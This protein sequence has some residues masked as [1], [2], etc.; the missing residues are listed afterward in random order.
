VNETIFYIAQLVA[1]KRKGELSREEELRLQ[2]LLEQHPHLLQTFREL[3]GQLLHDALHQLAQVDTKNAQHSITTRL[4]GAQRKGKVIST[5]W[6]RY[7]AA[8]VITIGIGSYVYFIS[9][10]EEPAVTQSKQIPAQTDVAPGGNKA[11]LTL[12]DG[13]KI[14]LDSLANGQIAT[15][16]NATITK[17]GD[18]I[19]YASQ[20][21]PDDAPTLYNTMTTPRGGQYQLTLPDGTKVWLNAESSIT[22]PTVFNGTERK[23]SITGEAYFEVTHDKHKPFRV[24][25]MRT[26]Y[27]PMQIEVLGTKFNINAYNEEPVTNTTLI[28]G[29]VRI[30]LHASRRTNNVL[31]LKPG[32]QGQLIDQKLVLAKDPDAEQAIAWKNG[33]F[34]FN[35]TTVDAA[36]RQISRWYD[37]TIQYEGKMPA[38]KF[39]GEIG[40]NLNL[41]Q[42]LKILDGVVVKLKLEGRILHVSTL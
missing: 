24:Q 5:G 42:L 8:I 21:S 25:C 37:V 29:S 11:T 27:P 41:S 9:Q 15:Q 16:A 19:S 30:T 23:V 22:Y 10:K 3:E 40:R 34:D 33:V 26:E 17:V 14:I 32:Q 38:G 7:A 36:M 6:I 20:P 28:E 1:A 31:T 13:S 2:Q 35:N 39:G 4:F 12:A 18:R